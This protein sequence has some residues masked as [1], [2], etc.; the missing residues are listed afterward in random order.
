MILVVSFFS[1]LESLESLKS[2]KTP[3]LST[4]NHKS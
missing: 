3:K 1:V 2:L 4:E